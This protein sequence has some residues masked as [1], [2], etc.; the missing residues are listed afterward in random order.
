MPKTLNSPGFWNSLIDSFITESERVPQ[1]DGAY[2]FQSNG[3][4]AEPDPI[5]KM[6]PTPQFHESLGLTN[7]P[8]YS[9]K[10]VDGM[11]RDIRQSYES[12]TVQ[13]QAG[14]LPFSDAEPLL[15]EAMRDW[16]AR[17]GTKGF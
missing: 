5:K 1:S 14:R 9:R 17:G 10:H 2:K 15:I 11:N 12:G 7:D 13:D 3:Q 8:N 6:M 16:L 4:S